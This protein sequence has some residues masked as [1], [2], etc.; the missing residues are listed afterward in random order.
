MAKKKKVGMEVPTKNELMKRYPNMIVA[1]ENDDSHLPVLPSRC[2]AFN[3]QICG[4]IPYGK[5]LELFGEE[6][7]GKSA[8]AL[9]FASVT[10]D[11]GGVVLWADAEQ[12]FTNAWA[13]QNNIDLS[14]IIIF[15]ETSV[16]AIS[17]W[18]ADMSIYW[19]S[20]LTKNE[21]ILFV[22]DSMAA[23]DCTENINSK[24]VDAKAD[25]GNRAKAIYKMFRIRSELLFKLGVCQIYINQLRKNLSAGMFGDPD[26]LHHDTMVPFTDGTSMRIG[27]IVKNKVKGLVWS[28]NEV[29]K[30]WEEK[31][32]RGWVEKE[33]TNNWLSIVTEGPG[34]KNGR[35][36]II[37]TRKHL[38]YTQRG[39]V[40]AGE[41]TLED[42]LIT[43]YEALIRGTSSGI[44]D[45][46]AFMYGMFIGDSSIR[47]RKKNTACI[48]LQDNSNPEY[49]DWKIN[50]LKGIVDFKETKTVRGM[51][52][53]V[54]PHTTELAI[55]KQHIGDRNPLT[56]FGFGLS[57]DIPALTLAIWYM[58]D[59][60]LD[61]RGRASISISPKRVN[62]YWLADRLTRAGYE[63][64][65]HQTKNLM[66]SSLGQK[67]LFSKIHSFV[68]SCMWY[69][70][71]KE[72]QNYKD[73]RLDDSYRKLLPLEVN[74]I[75]IGKAGAR[76]NKKPHK[77]DLTIEG[78]HNFLAGST[79][80]GVLVHNTTPG[81]KAL[82]FYASIRVGFYAGKQV[83][84]KIKGRERRVGKLASIRIKKNKVGP[85]RTTIKGAPFYFV[86][87]YKGYVGFDPYYFLNEIFLDSETIS[88]NSSG[89]YS[90][91]GV[92]ICRG[93]DA[94]LKKLENDDAFRRK[95]LR[96]AEINTIGNLRKKLE[97]I[98]T[99]LFPINKGIKYESQSEAVDDEDEDQ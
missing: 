99:N 68:P 23:L 88:K 93:E 51:R 89:T 35:N 73:F 69:K 79:D 17:D 12:S 82:A 87:E 42:K 48:H 2:L 55:I 81:G 74:I 4:G 1:S 31:P 25:M 65:P 52:K 78:N 85:P 61:K 26:C 67:N 10:T 16:E 71:P 58:D 90:L 97:S 22:T 75:S 36:G 29:T 44:S 50:K 95:L 11:L 77:Y 41:L 72:F 6:S 62:L 30:Q 37:C 63:C 53:M 39:W 86:E 8:M 43:K 9:S 66:F 24:M 96:K 27:D 98:E 14:R 60:H 33:P 34:T 7:S 38:M 83:T 47:I 45:L 94:F 56:V 46:S 54:S 5:I 59:G 19:R 84:G 21:P 49:L 18:V 70:L 20:I 32:I 3:Y 64:K 40:K 13:K 80:A 15:R 28:L 92:T 76:N 57:E 91:K